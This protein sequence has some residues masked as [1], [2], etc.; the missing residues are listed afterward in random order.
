MGDFVVSCTVGL[1]KGRFVQF[2]KSEVSVHIAT[3]PPKEEIIEIEVLGNIEPDMI[4]QAVNAAIAGCK[5][6]M[7]SIRKFLGEQFTKK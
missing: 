2:L 6:P 7:Q 5:E 4:R 1:D 3:I